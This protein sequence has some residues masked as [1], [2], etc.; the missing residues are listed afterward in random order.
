MIEKQIICILC[1]S[2]MAKKW[3]ADETKAELLRYLSQP[4][5]VSTLKDNHK[6][7]GPKT[8]RKLFQFIV[9]Q[10]IPLN[11]HPVENHPP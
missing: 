1:V 10:L 8:P 11:P 7:P 3:K 5:I 6:F 2:G 4:G 9:V